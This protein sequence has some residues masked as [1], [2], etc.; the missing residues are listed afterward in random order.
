MNLLVVRFSSFGD[1][2][3]A[4]EIVPHIHRVAPE[5]S[6][7]WLVRKDFADLINTQPGIRKVHEFD[8]RDSIWYLLKLSWVLAPRY[9]HL[10]DAHCNLRS[11]I[12]RFVF[13]LRWTFMGRFF[14]ARIL[15]RSKERLR[16]LLYFKFRLGRFRLRI[17][18]EPYKGA[19]SYLIPLSRWFPARRLEFTHSTWIPSSIE[20]GTTRAA[21][22]EWKTKLEGPI[23]AFAPSA[24]WP[25]KRWPVDRWLDL[26]KLILKHEPKSRFLLLGGPDDH[27]LADIAKELGPNIGFS[28]VGRTTLMESASLLS[29]AD[30][31]VANDTGLLHVADRLQKPLVGIIGPTAFGYPVGKRSKIAEVPN[32]E[33]VCKPCSKDGRD[34]C[35]NPDRLRCLTL[36]HPQHVLTQLIKALASDGIA[37]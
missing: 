25:N 12:V 21:F 15:V 27:F 34:R 33:L 18:P 37:N 11:A 5:A 6:I 36:V 19:V 26:A 14:P 29:E 8:R 30:A 2:F 13:A 28:A 9:T 17:F 10:Y 4:I 23:I 20:S 3:Q 31:L 22:A 1:I 16:R 32:Q 24:A 7:D 35:R